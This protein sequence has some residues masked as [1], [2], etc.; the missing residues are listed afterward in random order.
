MPPQQHCR[1]QRRQASRRG[2]RTPRTFFA[3]EPPSSAT[4]AGLAGEVNRPRL[5]ARGIPMARPTL[6]LVSAWDA[7]RGMRPLDIASGLVPD[8]AAAEPEADVSVLSPSNSAKALAWLL[9]T[10]SAW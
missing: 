10:L 3:E 4:P 8:I 6:A 7:D 9:S 5:A 1:H 2:G